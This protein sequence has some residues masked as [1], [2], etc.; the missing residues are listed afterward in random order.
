MGIDATMMGFLLEPETAE[1]GPGPDQRSSSGFRPFQK[2]QNKIKILANDFSDYITGPEG[3]GKMKLTKKI[4][5]NFVNFIVQDPYSLESKLRA[6]VMGSKHNENNEDIDQDNIG[7]AKV[8]RMEMYAKLVEFVKDL[9]ETINWDPFDQAL[10][11]IGLAI[12]NHKNAEAQ[13]KF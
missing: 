8:R 7:L 12:L 5:E 13:A 6:F 10:N 1:D 2:I 4:K 11:A 9:N 3:T